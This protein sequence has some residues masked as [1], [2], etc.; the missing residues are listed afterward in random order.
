MTGA[1][2]ERFEKVSSFF[3][4]NE[5]ALMR[6]AASRRSEFHFHRNQLG[7]SF[8]IGFKRDTP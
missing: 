1:G 4:A 8:V 6:S 3:K 2:A 7:G 5:L